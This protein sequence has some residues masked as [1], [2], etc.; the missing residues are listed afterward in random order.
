MVHITPLSVLL[1]QP[2]PGRVDADMVARGKDAGVR[3][4]RFRIIAEAVRRMIL[5][6]RIDQKILLSCPILQGD[7]ENGP[8]AV[9]ENPVG[10]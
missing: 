8:L 1:D 3:D 7:S 4:D 9:A 5:L 2:V 10:L 6:C